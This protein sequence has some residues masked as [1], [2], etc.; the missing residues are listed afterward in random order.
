M[1]PK[2]RKQESRIEERYERSES[3]PEEAMNRE[4][5][6]GRREEMCCGKSVRVNRG[7]GGGGRWGTAGLDG[8][9]LKKGSEEEE[10]EVV[11]WSG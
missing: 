10:Q 3:R 11:V 5:C 7:G 6:R 9:T 2:T 1:V 8:L 4:R